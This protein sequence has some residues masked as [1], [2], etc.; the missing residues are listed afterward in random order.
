M[1]PEAELTWIGWT[2]PSGHT[3]HKVWVAL[4]GLALPSGSL[5]CPFTAWWLSQTIG[6]LMKK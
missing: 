4:G 3:P 6:T 2:C 5:S 1:T